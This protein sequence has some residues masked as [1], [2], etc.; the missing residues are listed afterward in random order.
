MRT[1]SLCLISLALTAAAC[2][3]DPLF[4]G[5]PRSSHEPG[6]VRRDSLA[7]N[8]SQD[9]EH[10]WLTAVRFPDGY[11]W[12]A[13]TCAVDGEVWIDLYRNGERVRSVPAGACVHPDMHR[14]VGGHLY[15]DWSTETETVVSRDGAE[16]FRFEGREA[17]RGFLVRED[18]IHTLG[19][20]RDGD[21]FTYRIDGRVL[22]RSETG[23]VLGGPDGP[24]A[25]GGAFVAYGEDVWYVCCFPSEQGKEYHVMRNG[26]RYLAF[27][28]TDGTRE[29]LFARGK[30]SRLR[31]RSRGGM[32][33]ETDGKEIRL[34]VGGGEA[35]LWS[36]LAPWEE[37]VAAL[38]CT[39]TAGVK[40]YYLK[41]ALGKSFTTF[42][43]ETV[44]D[45]LAE[46]DRLGWTVTNARGDLLRVRWSDGGVTEGTG[47]FLVCGR[48]ALLR[49]GC[50]FL[51][52]T[53]RDGAPNRL[54]EDGVHTDIPFNGYF[55][56]VTVE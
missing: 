50:L 3:R 23:A 49:D 2:I 24:G 6:N 54:Q 55:T 16:L 10:I 15:L 45:L 17:V 14:Y 44:S 33:L 28:A 5:T 52:L 35:C 37:D 20:D 25:D 47:G 8:P 32:V 4:P 40:R 12:E 34:G 36:R 51:A 9:G 22:Y 31:S 42:P 43:G 48:C 11:A 46:G 7:T 38:V 26:E 27:P 53:G 21:G 39:R 19:Q 1:T 41:T 13:D 18:G 56:S 30:V 29:V